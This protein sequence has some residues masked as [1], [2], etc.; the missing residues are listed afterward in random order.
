MIIHVW[1]VFCIKLGKIWNMSASSL[2]HNLSPWCFSS[3][4]YYI[5]LSA[6]LF[7]Q[8][9]SCMILGRFHLSFLQN[10]HLFP[11]FSSNVS[12]FFSL[13]WW[14]PHWTWQLKLQDLPRTTLTK[15]MALLKI[16]LIPQFK[17]S[18]NCCLYFSL[19]L[20]KQF[21]VFLFSWLEGCGCRCSVSAFIF[22]PFFFLICH[23]S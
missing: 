3:P 23:W 1:N 10:K 15:A 11:L 9:P 7:R 2:H 6:L 20:Y 5:I 17:R 4:S 16:G 18:F 12:C 21:S 13:V 8:F 19:A 14:V 22:F